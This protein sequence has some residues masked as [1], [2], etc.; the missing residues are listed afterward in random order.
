MILRGWFCLVIAVAP[1]MGGTITDV[2]SDTTTLVGTGDTL[3]FHV[4]TWNY[5]LHATDAGLP[6]YPAD[7]QF[8]LVSDVG[9]IGATFGATLESPGGD[10]SVSFGNLTFGAGS[11][12]GSDYAGA[13]ATLQGYLHVSPAIGSALFGDGSVVLAL[14][15]QGPAVPVGLPGYD[16]NQDMYTSLSGGQLD[17]GAI[18]GW[19]GQEK[20]TVGFLDFGGA[21]G[22]SDESGVPEPR[23]GALLVAGGMVLCGVSMALGRLSRHR[24]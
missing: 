16:L 6:L 13:D 22:F 11:F 21:L 12:T 14:R 1:A 4:Y 3:F 2:S 15:N 18:P 9:S 19:V 8:A 24:K 10:V 20:Q 17:V 23:T 7:L 5:G